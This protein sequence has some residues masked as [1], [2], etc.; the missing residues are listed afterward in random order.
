M[1]Y[2]FVIFFYCMRFLWSVMSVWYK[3]HIFEKYFF[4]KFINLKWHLTRPDPIY[5]SLC[6]K[7]KINYYR[8]FLNT[9]KWYIVDN[10]NNTIISRKHLYIFSVFN[11]YKKNVYGFFFLFYVYRLSYDKN[12]CLNK[13]YWI[14]IDHYPP[15]WIFGTGKRNL[16]RS[17]PLEAEAS[18]IK[19]WVKVWCPA[20]VAEVCCILPVEAPVV[21][22]S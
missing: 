4:L 5:I 17:A 9:L 3:Q 8:I 2:S 18:R 21:D 11:I 6:T 1:K 14:I 13:R 15:D 16:R 10:N 22:C 7:P 19:T 20:F 12:T